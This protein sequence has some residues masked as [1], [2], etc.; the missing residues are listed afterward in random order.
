M[1]LKSEDHWSGMNQGP[2]CVPTYCSHLD[3][4]LESPHFGLICLSLGTQNICDLQQSF[5][6]SQDEK[7]Y[8]QTPH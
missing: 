3:Y 1:A 7:P 6:L 4:V 2:L 5:H 8:Y